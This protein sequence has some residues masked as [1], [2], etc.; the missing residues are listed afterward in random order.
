MT[1]GL[2]NQVDSVQA[3]QVIQVFH[4]NI[5][6]FDHYAIDQITVFGDPPAQ[7]EKRQR[8]VIDDT[9]TFL[10][11]SP[12]SGT[13]VPAEVKVRERPSG[14]IQLV[15]LSGTEKAPLGITCIGVCFILKAEFDPRTRIG[16]VQVNGFLQRYAC[17]SW[18][19]IGFQERK[20]KVQSRL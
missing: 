20:A 4:L 12:K 18:V 9:R 17:S 8:I 2:A 10:S 1:N 13:V 14:Q 3:E 5:P 11:P 15:H 6:P 7:T 19:L 16:R